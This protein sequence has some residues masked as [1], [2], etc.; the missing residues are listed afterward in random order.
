MGQ[1]ETSRYEVILLQAM[2]AESQHF[3]SCVRLL[4]YADSGAAESEGSTRLRQDDEAAGVAT[5]AIGAAARFVRDHGS[6]ADEPLRRLAAHAQ[7]LVGL[8]PPD[9]HLFFQLHYVDGYPLS[10]YAT[11]T[12]MDVGAAAGD[13]HDVI[14]ALRATGA[15]WTAV[16]QGPASLPKEDR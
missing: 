4:A 16:L 1:R 2:E 6:L 8:L 10:V 5:A 12:E 3:R 7:V 9:L 13:Y 11:A 14:L 15:D